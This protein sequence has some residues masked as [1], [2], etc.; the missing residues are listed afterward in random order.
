[1][2]RQ[3]YPAAILALVQSTTYP[4]LP[5]LEELE[6]LRQALTEQIAPTSSGAT[7]LNRLEKK[8]KRKGDEAAIEREKV[9][10]DRQ[11]VALEA[12]EKSGARLEAIERARIEHASH[13]TAS[14]KTKGSPAPGSGQGQKVKRERVSREPD[15][16]TDE[17]SWADNI[18]VQLRLRPRMPLLHHSDF[19]P[20]LNLSH[21][22]SNS[23]R[24]RR[25]VSWTATMKVSVC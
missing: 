8:E 14:S 1:M 21:T 6:L 9:R 23:R 4:P 5:N 20:A 17:L 15:S 19:S 7:P 22:V 16:P 25:S 18:D 11:R 3:S 10:D 12:N 24:K 13:A 2:P